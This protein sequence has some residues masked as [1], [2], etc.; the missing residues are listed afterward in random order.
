[1]KT[2]LR[3][4]ALM[5]AALTVASPAGSKEIKDEDIVEYR[6]SVM[7]VIGW[8]FG[9]MVAMVKDEAPYAGKAF[10][11]HARRLREMSVMA[12]E[13]FEKKAMAGKTDAK[14]KIWD[15]W[16]DFETKMKEM[17]DQVANLHEVSKKQDIGAI[18]GMFGDVGKSCKS[19]HDEYTEE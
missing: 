8:N 16:S 1:M 5:F 19:C 18:R 10:E 11:E 14:E 15:N 3:G 6:Q 2:T 12:L 7:N 13:G 4:A 17:N 9:P